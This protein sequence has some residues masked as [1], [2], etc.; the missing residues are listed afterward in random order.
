MESICTSPSR[1]HERGRERVKKG[2][3]AVLVLVVLGGAG[4][5]ASV[6]FGSNKN[7]SLPPR[8]EAPKLA[9][10]YHGV[11]GDANSV[12]TVDKNDEAGVSGRM[13]FVFA[14]K[15][16]SYGTFVGQY[17]EGTLNVKYTFMSEGIES[18][19]P[20]SFV[21]SGDNFQ[22]SGFTYLPATDC[23]SFLK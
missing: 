22:G 16:S 11:V 5:F 2:L 8:F 14:Q 21:Q 10:C 20:I 19:D 1:I 6:K 18:T 4:I 3:V 15:D 23:A 9:A 7:V 12:F 17:E 13:S